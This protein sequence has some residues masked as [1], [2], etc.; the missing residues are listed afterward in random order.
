LTVCVVEQSA[1][2]IEADDSLRDDRRSMETNAGHQEELALMLDGIVKTIK[3][4]LQK[5]S[6]DA[7]VALWYNIHVSRV[8]DKQDDASPA[9]SI[10][11]GAHPEAIALG[12]PRVS[13]NAGT[14]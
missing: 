11:V 6:R 12:V 2:G 1:E 8:R 4:D 13:I 14:N 5:F 7:D 10:N 9:A 3:V